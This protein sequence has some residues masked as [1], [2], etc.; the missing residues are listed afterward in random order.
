MN[1]WIQSSF[2]IWIINL[3]DIHQVPFFASSTSGK[4]HVDFN[5]TRYIASL[6]TIEETMHVLVFIS[7]LAKIIKLPDIYY[8]DNIGHL[9]LYYIDLSIN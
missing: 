7:S 5:D 4:M 2:P 1:Y 3:Y 8:S 6:G 9:Q